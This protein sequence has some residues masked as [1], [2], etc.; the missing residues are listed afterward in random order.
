MTL[1]YPTV[2]VYYHLYGMTAGTYG[3]GRVLDREIYDR[4][5]DKEGRQGMLGGSIT[6]WQILCHHLISPCLSQTTDPARLSELTEWGC[7]M[8]P[9]SNEEYLVI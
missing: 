4:R 2:A 8:K 1:A 9:Y 5:R 7:L 6:T 3:S